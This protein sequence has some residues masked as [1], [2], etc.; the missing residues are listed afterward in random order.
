M[1]LRVLV[2]D[3]EENW[4]DQFQ[5][6]L[7]TMGCEV[8]TSWEVH[9]TQELLKQ[10]KYDLVLL[11]ICL[12]HFDLSYLSFQQLCLFLKEN[13]GDVPILAM[14][15]KSIAPEFMFRLREEHRVADFVNKNSLSLPDFRRLCRSANSSWTDVAR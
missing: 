6:I 9:D 14:S 5:D 12:G 4:R 11:D 2:V 8:N 7:V 1:P 13:C 3:D 10:I 15:A